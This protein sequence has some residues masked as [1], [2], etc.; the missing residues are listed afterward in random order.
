MSKRVHPLLQD[1]YMEAEDPSNLMVMVFN[2]RG[3]CIYGGVYEF[4]SGGRRFTEWLT[5]LPGVTASLV[6]QAAGAIIARQDSMVYYNTSGGSVS[7]LVVG[8]ALPQYGTKVGS[9]ITD[10]IEFGRVGMSPAE[11]TRDSYSISE[12]ERIESGPLDALTPCAAFAVYNDSGHPC[13]I[14]AL[15]DTD[16]WVKI[17]SLGFGEFAHFNIG[18]RDW[19]KV[20]FTSYPVNVVLLR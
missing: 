16:A 12:V 10:Y 19:S 4:D 2:S 8:F 1:Y 15:D 7:P 3:R 14:E 5:S 17:G 13:D 9:E 20:R 18:I 6:R 11:A